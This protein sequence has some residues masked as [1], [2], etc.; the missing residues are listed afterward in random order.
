MGHRPS[1]GAAIAFTPTVLVTA[2][3]PARR[4]ACRGACR[5]GVRCGRRHVHRVHRASGRSPTMDLRD[6]CRLR[7]ACRGIE[8][9]SPCRRAGIEAAVQRDDGAR[10]FDMNRAAVA[11]R[12]RRARAAGVRKACTSRARASTAPTRPVRRGSSATPGSARRREQIPRSALPRCGA[13]G[14]DVHGLSPQEPLR[15][16]HEASHLR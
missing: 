15:A 16:R 8:G 1:G 10:V 7:G 6:A 3:R 14:L 12:A 9:V 13:A 11:A 5:R 2:R 4:L